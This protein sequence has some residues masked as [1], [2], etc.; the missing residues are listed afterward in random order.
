MTPA[1]PSPSTPSTRER[2]Q[3]ALAQGGLIDI[4]T[5]GR[6]SGEFRRIEIVFF[7]FDGHAYV[8]G[9]PGRRGWYANILDDPRLTFHLKGAVEADLPARALPITDEA[10]R[11]ALLSRITRQ[12][13][14]EPELERFVAGSPLIEVAFDDPML[15]GA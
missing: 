9:M 5:R 12:W 13:R 14:R 1:S 7:N 10:S 11:R 15:L 4:T 8:S 3:A 2:I 6:R